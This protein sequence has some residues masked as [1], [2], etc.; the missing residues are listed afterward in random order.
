MTLR[1]SKIILTCWVSIHLKTLC[2]KALPR[3]WVLYKTMP[4]FKQVDTV[5]CTWKYAEHK[6]VRIQKV[7]TGLNRFQNRVVSFLSNYAVTVPLKK[8][9]NCTWKSSCAWGRCFSKHGSNLIVISHLIYTSRNLWYL[10]SVINE[11]WA[12]IMQRLLY[13]R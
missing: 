12:P 5:S 2:T 10:I 13:W 6:N 3:T 11:I 4:S 9:K 7:F 8:Q 1:R